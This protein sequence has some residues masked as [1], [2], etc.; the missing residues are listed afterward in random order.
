MRHTL[1][2]RNQTKSAHSAL[3]TVHFRSSNEL[4]N[5]SSN[6]IVRKKMLLMRTHETWANPFPKNQIGNQIND[7]LHAKKKGN[8]NQTRLG[9]EM[10]RPNTARGAWSQK[11]ESEL[12][13]LSSSVS[14][15]HMAC[16]LPP[17]QTN[18][19]NF[20]AIS[21]YKFSNVASLLCAICKL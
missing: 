21:C 11:Q 19:K 7:T 5:S 18:P 6:W 17:S 13:E 3:I 1:F 20:A 14:I 15:L 9:D 12:Y 10:S 2:L 8:S 16:L 4:R